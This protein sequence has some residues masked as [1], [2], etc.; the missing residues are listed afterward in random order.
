ML[1]YL[2]DVISNKTRKAWHRN[3]ICII[4]PLR[5]PSLTTEYTR[6]EPVIRSFLVFVVIGLSKL[7]NERSRYLIWYTMASMRR[8]CKAILR[9]GPLLA[10]FHQFQV[11]DFN[12]IH[13]W[14]VFFP[15]Q[16][17]KYSELNMEIHK[18][19]SLKSSMHLQFQYIL[20]LFIDPRILSVAAWYYQDK[21]SPKPSLKWPVPITWKDSSRCYQSMQWALVHT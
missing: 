12:S 13:I 11:L 4:G 15:M 21:N 17:Q 18:S 2:F 6:I 16:N 8:H 5:N 7:F 3:V 20:A 1:L 9:I 19:L 14:S 10:S